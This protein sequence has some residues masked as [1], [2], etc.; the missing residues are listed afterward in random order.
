MSDHVR[1]DLLGSPRPVAGA[2][3]LTNM[4]EFCRWACAKQL[5][6]AEN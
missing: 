3:I 6:Q 5:A 1:K 2:K 4:S